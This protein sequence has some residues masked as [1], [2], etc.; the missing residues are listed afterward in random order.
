M[1]LMKA[2]KNLVRDTNHTQNNEMTVNFIFRFLC[3]FVS[4]I[5]D[6]DAP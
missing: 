3:A 2:C 1:K 5:C 6:S 4:W